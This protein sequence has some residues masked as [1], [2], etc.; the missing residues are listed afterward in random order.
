[1]DTRIIATA[2]ETSRMSAHFAEAASGGDPAADAVL[3]SM[4]EEQRIAFVA[5]LANAQGELMDSEDVHGV[6]NSPPSK[7]ASLLQTLLVEQS[8]DAAPI[9]G[10]DTLEAKFDTHDWA[11]WL[12]T[13]WEMVKGATPFAWRA[14][15]AGAQ[16]VAQFSDGARMALFGDWGTGLYGAPEIAKRIS[17]DRGKVDVVLHLGDVYYSGKATEFSSRFTALWPKRN[18]ALN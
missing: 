16:R 4:P 8:H 15:A 3:A 18:G 13:F 17:E 6:M 10:K 2:A 11:G 5:A 1:M 14:P 9:V 12:G 7:A